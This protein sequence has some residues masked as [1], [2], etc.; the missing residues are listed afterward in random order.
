MHTHV[1]LMVGMSIM[2]FSKSMNIFFYYRVNH[3]ISPI[4]FL[5]RYDE[6]ISRHN[7]VETSIDFKIKNTIEPA[8]IWLLLEQHV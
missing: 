5:K 8:T 2:K 7:M 4:A 1:T 6:T 3:H